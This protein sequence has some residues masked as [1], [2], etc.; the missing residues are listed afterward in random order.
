MIQFPLTEIEGKHAYANYKH[1]MLTLPIALGS[2]TIVETGLGHGFSSK[3]F[4]DALAANGGS[5][6][7]F[8]LDPDAKVVDD[9]KKIISTRYP[10]VRWYLHVGKSSELHNS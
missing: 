1:L 3:I 5:L 6:H 10:N 7:T 9:I 8:E 4:I 2:T